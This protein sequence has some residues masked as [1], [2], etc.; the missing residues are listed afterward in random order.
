MLA[1]CRVSRDVGPALAG[2][3][4]RALLFKRLP[5]HSS[6]SQVNQLRPLLH[7]SF[8]LGY[9]TIYTGSRDTQTKCLEE[10]LGVAWRPRPGNRCRDKHR[11]S[12]GGRLSRKYDKP[13][14]GLEAVEKCT[15]DIVDAMPEL[16]NHRGQES[17]HLPGSEGQ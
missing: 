6:N 2:E 8:G 11:R 15:D 5:S 10:E 12:S 4:L 9:N 3:S 1:S 17:R 14:L 16:R 13:H 7:D